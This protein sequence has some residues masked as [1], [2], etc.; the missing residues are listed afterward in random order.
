MNERMQTI[1]VKDY[2][3]VRL[4][5]LAVVLATFDKMDEAERAATLK[6]MKSKY[7]KEWPSENTRPITQ[8]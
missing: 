4:N 6:V 8:D 1:N 2:G 5:R 7:A 3:N